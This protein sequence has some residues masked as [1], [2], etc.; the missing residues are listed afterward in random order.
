MSK[1][2]KK[3]GNLRLSAKGTNNGNGFD[4]LYNFTENHEFVEFTAKKEF[5]FIQPWMQFPS[6]KYTDECMRVSIELVHRFNNFEECQRQ[7]EFYKSEYLKEVDRN[8]HAFERVVE[9][10]K[11]D[12]TVSANLIAMFLEANREKIIGDKND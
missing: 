3:F 8:K 6:Q 12:K 11:K 9:F 10:L 7:L 2:E 4:I 1:E 5:Y